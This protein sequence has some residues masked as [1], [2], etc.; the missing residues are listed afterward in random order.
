MGVNLPGADS[1]LAPFCEQVQRKMQQIAISGVG[2]Q[3]ILFITKLLAEAAM[4]MDCSVLISET[5]GMAQRGGNVIS[6]LKVSGC[7]AKDAPKNGG[8][9]PARFTSPLIRPGKADIFLVLHTDGLAAHGFYV[10]PDGKTFCARIEPSDKYSLDA[11]KMASELGSAIS[12][13]LVLLGFAA[14][15]GALFCKAEDLRAV[16]KRY[17]GKRMDLNLKAFDAG[18]SEAEKRRLAAD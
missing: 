9:R 7:G 10:S 11:T 3:G 16:L 13:N 18:V 2:G 14:A 1:L 8:N 15:S 5:H 6:H 4:D 17:G 12:G